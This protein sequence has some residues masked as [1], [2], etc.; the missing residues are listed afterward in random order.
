VWQS[1]ACSIV[2]RNFTIDEWKQFVGADTPYQRVCPAFPSDS[3]VIQDELAQAHADVQTGHQQ[4][5]Q[6]LYTKATQEAAQFDNADLANNVCLGG[7]TDQFA[8]EVMPACQQAVSLDPYYGQYRDSRGLARALRGDT[9]GAINDFKVFVQWANDEYVNTTGIDLD[10]QAQYKQ[11]IAERSSWIQH[12]EAGKHP[13][14]ARVLE[15]LRVESHID[16]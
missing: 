3:S 15:M 14:S 1:L 5:A 12:L 8:A 11:F 10:T 6:A 2:D 9:Q 16:G 4:D 13:F 7:S